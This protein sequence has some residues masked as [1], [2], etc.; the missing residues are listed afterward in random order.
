MKRHDNT[1]LY[2]LLPIILCGLAIPL[3]I[4]MWLGNI[5]FSKIKWGSEMD[6]E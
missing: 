4:F 6:G 1:L 3:S 2:E 5:A